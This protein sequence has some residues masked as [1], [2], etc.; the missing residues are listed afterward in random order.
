MAT[1]VHESVSFLIY[2]KWHVCVAIMTIY[3]SSKSASEETT[4]MR[5]DDGG[6]VPDGKK[7]YIAIVHTNCEKRVME[8]FECMGVDAF[9]PVQTCVREVRGR[10][11]EMERIVLRSRVF[12][13]ISPDSASR[14]RV[15]RVLHVK[16][17][18]TYPGTNRDAVI[19]DWQMQQFRYMLGVLDSGVVVTDDIK[20]GQRV[21]VT[22]GYLKGLVG[23]VCEV[24]SQKGTCIGVGMDILGYACVS[25]DVSD[26]EFLE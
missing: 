11:K 17:F 10:K 9:L 16:G 7:W 3:D 5:T 26:I 8:Y 6:A 20:I 15:K 21:R 1:F 2:R 13:R 23:N 19:P 24:P 25:I 12:V 4:V 14:V 22:R 18:V